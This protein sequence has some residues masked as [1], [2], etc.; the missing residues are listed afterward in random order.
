MMSVHS[1]QL[2]VTSQKSKGLILLVTNLLL[3][4]EIFASSGASFLKLGVGARALGMGSAYTA[5]SNDVTALHW[6]PAGLSRLGKKEI[7]VMHAELF[8]N[9]R[10]DFFGYAHPTSKGAFGIGAV[11]LSQGEMEGRTEG[12]EKKSDFSASDLAITFGC[13]RF[14]NSN[15]SLGVN[16][17]LIQSKIAG[18]S[19]TGLAFDMGTMWKMSGSKTQLGFAIQNM[20]PK[21][22]FVDEG[23]NLPLTLIGGAGYRFFSNLLI[24]ADLKHQPYNSRTSFSLG[25]EF[26]PVS[27]LSL[28]AGYLTN[29]LKPTSSNNNNLTEKLSNLSGVGLGLGFKIG[30]SNID[31]SFTPAGELGN[32]QRISLSMKF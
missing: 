2:R 8:S 32:T 30:S 12:R 1:T 17:K 9:N 26:S 19:A 16:V 7:S 25:T 3:V 10:F 24:S 29:A 13:S 11:Y 6:N 28:R 20:G 15:A 23:Y 14:V 18:A 5:L 31:Y 21:M 27:M 4:T 22:K